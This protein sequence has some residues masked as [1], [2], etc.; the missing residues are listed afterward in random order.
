MVARPDIRNVRCRF[1]GK[2]GGSALDKQSDAWS[3]Y[4]EN[5]DI[6]AA[7]LKATGPWE[8]NAG[9]DVL[10]DFLVERLP[11]ALV[12]YDPEQGPMRPW[13]FTVFVRYARRRLLERASVK[14][15]WL[16]FE[17]LTDAEMVRL[18]QEKPL[19]EEQKKRIRNALQKLPYEFQMCLLTYFGNEPEFG[20]I[21]ALA[22]KFDWSRHRAQQVLLRAL[23]A[24][25]AQLKEGVLADEELE[26]CRAHL[27]HGETWER[28]AGK[29][30]KSEHQA[31]SLMKSALTKFGA[32]LSK[33]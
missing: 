25:S 5:R 21:R 13:L 31:R 15:R 9:M 14:N 28:I 23:A 12:T 3:V 2:Q 4:L 17:S 26:V 8:I 11:Q 10:H 18:V 29:L 32:S 16:S 6:F 27:V 30:K 22:R 24:L 20:N 1:G 33:T 19:S 7:G